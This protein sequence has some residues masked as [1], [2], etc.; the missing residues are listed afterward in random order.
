MAV[1]LDTQLL[2]ALSAGVR[3][4]N[5]QPLLPPLGSCLNASD[6]NIVYA[7]RESDGEGELVREEGGGREGEGERERERERERHYIC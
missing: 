3:F 4:D 7:V 2:L 5:Q 6:S 1:F